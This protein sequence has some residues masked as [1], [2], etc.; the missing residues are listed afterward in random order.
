MSFTPLDPPI[1]LHVID[2]GDGYAFAVIDY[3]QEHNLIWVTG[4]N[5]TGEIWCAPNPKVRLQPNWSMG[6]GR[7]AKS[8]TETFQFPVPHAA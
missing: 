1:P 4:M 2:K 6:R 7:P 3:G 5:E 8:E